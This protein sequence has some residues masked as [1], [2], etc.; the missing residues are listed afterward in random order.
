MPAS[1][2]KLIDPKASRST[3]GAPARARTSQNAGGRLEER[4][5]ARFFGK[6]GGHL[7]D[8]VRVL[9]FR[10]DDPG[11]PRPGD[12]LEIVPEPQGRRTVHAHVRGALRGEPGG[13]RRAGL[14]FLLARHRVLKVEDHGVCPG[15]PGLLEAVGAIAGDEEV[16]AAG[17][18]TLSGGCE[19]PAPG[20]GSRNAR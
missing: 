10:Q 16:G 2:R 20:R 1:S 17:H 12:R 3:R 18:A 13:D 9:G 7:G 8:L 15:A 11:E 19:R 5:H 4:E 14:G 6:P